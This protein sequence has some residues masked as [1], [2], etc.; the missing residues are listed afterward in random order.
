[1]LIHRKKK[2]NK[3]T[4]AQR[5]YKY[6]CAKEHIR[7][8]KEPLDR[9]LPNCPACEQA[10]QAVSFRYVGRYTIPKDQLKK[11]KFSK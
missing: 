9:S 3:P 1:M 2:R 11:S 4:A 8:E 5:A 6:Q 10:G 7:I